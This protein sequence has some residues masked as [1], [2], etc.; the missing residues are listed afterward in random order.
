MKKDWF[1]K[2]DFLNVPTSLSYKNEYF[3]TTNVGA[4]LTVLFFVI[5]ITLTTYEIILLYKKNSFSLISNQYTDLSEV[6][7]FSQTPFLFQLI[8]DKGKV[9]NKD[10]KTFFMEAY[11]MEQSI[12]QYENGT[13]KK[14]VKNTKIE[15]DECD[16]IYANETEF[17]GLNL[18]RYICIKPGQNLTAFGLLGDPN[19]AYRGIRIYIN[20]CNGSNCYSDSEISK[21]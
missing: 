5:I 4:T 7:D 12:I 10:D 6:I 20:K 14:K 8:N 11:I 16:K 17:A 9:T 2:C 15:M 19:N 13:R 3:Y 18:S 21:K 1:R